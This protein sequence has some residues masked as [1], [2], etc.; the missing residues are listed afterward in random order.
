MVR[1]FTV[2]VS[3]QRGNPICNAKV[4]V[5]GKEYSTDGSGTATFAVRFSEENYNV[6]ST[7]EVWRNGALVARWKIDFFSTSPID[8]T[9]QDK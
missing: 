8:V 2:H 5:N 6:P 9:I 4:R 7:V 1:E 3:D